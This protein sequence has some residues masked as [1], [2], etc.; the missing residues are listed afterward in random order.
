M[1]WVCGKIMCKEAILDG[2]DNHWEK[3]THSYFL[4]RKRMETTRF[5]KVGTGTQGK[6]TGGTAIS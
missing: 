2:E 3:E 1:N 5:Q 6:L 4:Q